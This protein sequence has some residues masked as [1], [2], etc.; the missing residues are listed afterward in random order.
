M[1][2]KIELMVEC[3]PTRTNVIFDALS[4]ETSARLHASYDCHGLLLDDLRFTG[5]KLGVE[6]KE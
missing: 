4:R 6:D 2:S 3:Y 1:L 5:K